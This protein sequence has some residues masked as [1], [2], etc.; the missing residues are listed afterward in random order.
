VSDQ[1]AVDM[2]HWLLHNE[3]LWIGSS[4]SMN[5]VGAIQSIQL[6]Q[7]P[8]GSTIVT[9]V[10]DMGSRHVTR[11]WNPAFIRS[12]GLRW[13]GDIETSTDHDFAPDCLRNI[14]SSLSGKKETFK[15]R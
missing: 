3:G 11:F 13:P 4:S 5:V 15:E 12:W 14:I 2:A 6:L 10:C 8:I 7:L 1:E 9:I